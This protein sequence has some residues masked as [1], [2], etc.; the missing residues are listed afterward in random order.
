MWFVVGIPNDLVKKSLCKKLLTICL[1]CNIH[2]LKSYNLLFSITVLSV[3][4]IKTSVSCWV[5]GTSRNNKEWVTLNYF[6]NVRLLH[7]HITVTS[8]ILR[9][10][11]WF[12]FYLDTTNK[13]TVKLI[14]KS[15]LSTKLSC[16]VITKSFI[17]H[18]KH[19][20][21]N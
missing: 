16:N 19:Q 9:S 13:Y 18:T 10:C 21:T 7:W 4:K 14:L 17:A 3:Y 5:F 11:H 8:N 12:N 1:V 15:F 20:N 2:A 6:D